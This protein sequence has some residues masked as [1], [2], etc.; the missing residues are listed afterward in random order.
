MWQ[1]RSSPGAAGSTMRSVLTL[2]KLRL[3]VPE[4]LS[5]LINRQDPIA[6]SAPVTLVI[7][8]A[9]HSASASQACRQAWK[10]AGVGLRG[11]LDVP[12]AVADSH[13]NV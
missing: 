9:A 6:A 5:P 2:V 3:K 1:T 13:Q 10:D 11:E 12:I 4:V 8:T 7:A